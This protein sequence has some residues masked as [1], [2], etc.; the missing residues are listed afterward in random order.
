VRESTAVLNDAL[1][2]VSVVALWLV[3]QTLFLGGLS[4][5]RAQTVL[6]GEF[7][8]D[9]AAATAPLGGAIDPG[10]PVALLSMPRTGKELVVVEGTAA[11]DLLSGPG[12]RRDTALPGQEGASIVY[13]RAR[14]YGAPFADITALH[15]GDVI[16]TTTQQGAARFVVDGVRRAGDPVPQ[17]L[18]AGEARL[19]LVTAESTGPLSALSAGETVYVDATLSGKPFVAPAGRPLQVPEAEQAMSGDP[20][21]LPLLG[22]CLAGVLAVVALIAVAG[23]RWPR[24]L[25]WV[26]VSPLAIALAWASTDVAVQLLPSLL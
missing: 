14:T 2:M 15:P 1:L 7:R 24:T 3:A 17:P 4:E 9:L 26:V 18:G 20:S 12:H 13:G 8:A 22:L 6:F 5:G 23:R 19:T 10:T 21:V 16:E 25:V 11:G